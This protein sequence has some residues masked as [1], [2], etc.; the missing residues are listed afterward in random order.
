[1]NRRVIGLLGALLLTAPA[2]T[3]RAAEETAA[4]IAH[5][6]RELGSLNLVG[7][8]ADMKLVNVEKGGDRKERDLSTQSKKIDGQTRTIT[9]FKGPADVA[10]VAL[11]V[12]QGTAGAADDVSLYLPKIRRARKVAQSNRGDAF[13]ESEFSYADF[14]S[15]GVDETSSTREKDGA[16]DGKP[17]F[18]LTGAPKDSPYTKVVLY[19]D[20]ATYVPLKVDYFDKDGL[21]KVYTV[22]KVEK[23][24]DRQLATES[25]MENMRNGRR[26]LLSVS[27]LATADA[28]DTSFTERGLERG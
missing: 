7:L 5:K 9:R 11:L 21:L 23:Q 20:K 6:A 13:M 18:V 10:G 17:V 4:D 3:A 1:M 26:T 25:T 8:K 19:V 12:A 15:N 28:P 14:T 22:Q 24:M 2:L 27:K 16:V